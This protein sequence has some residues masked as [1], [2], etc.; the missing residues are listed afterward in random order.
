MVATMPKQNPTPPPPAGSGYDAL[1]KWLDSIPRPREV[2]IPTPEE[3]AAQA[4]RAEEVARVEAAVA[5][6]LS[7]EPDGA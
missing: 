2:Y 6:L 7:R 5:E 1:R 3:E 4:E